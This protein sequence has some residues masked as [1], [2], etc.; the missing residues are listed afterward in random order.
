[1]QQVLLV[2]YVI[3]T[4]AARYRFYT[5]SSRLRAGAEVHQIS[6]AGNALQVAA[7][8]AARERLQRAIASDAAMFRGAHA[9]RS[10]RARVTSKPVSSPAAEDGIEDALRLSPRSDTMPQPIKRAVFS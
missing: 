8:D 1:M 10:A 2:R 4:I 7:T 6:P 3:F 9:A 5:R